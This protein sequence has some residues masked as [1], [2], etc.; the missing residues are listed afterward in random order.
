MFVIAVIQDKIKTSPKNFDRDSTNDIIEEIEIKYSNKILQDVGLG[1]C[2]Y[3]FVKMEAAYIYPGEGS[4]HRVVVFRMVFFRPTIGEILEGTIIGCDASGLRVSL[5]FFDDVWV[6]RSDLHQPCIFQR[7]SSTGEPEYSWKYDSSADAGI[8][9]IIDGS[10]G[11]SSSPRP[12]SSGSDNGSPRA[13]SEGEGEGEGEGPITFLY[14]LGQEIRFK[15]RNVEF[16]TSTITAKGLQTFTVADEEAVAGISPRSIAVKAEGGLAA[17]LSRQPSNTSLP[18]GVGQ[19]QDVIGEGL[20]RR[21]SSSLTQHEVVG[22]EVVPAIPPAC[23]RVFG[24]TNHDGLGCVNWW[25]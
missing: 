9:M 15:V 2:F 25:S 22:G 20:G 13:G 21:R 8:E 17:Q 12:S 23:L 16:N 3:D 18:P 14:T 24:Y 19:V 7:N 5:G 4:A 10:D 6:P 11:G 1:I